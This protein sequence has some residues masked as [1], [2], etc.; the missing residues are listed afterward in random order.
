MQVKRKAREMGLK[1]RQERYDQHTLESLQH[2]NILYIDLDTQTSSMSIH[3]LQTI[4]MGCLDT[5]LLH[6]TCSLMYSG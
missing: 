4:K 1:A 2:V 6:D 5:P 3:C